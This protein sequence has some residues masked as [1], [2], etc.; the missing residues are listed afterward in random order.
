MHKNIL[1]R[2]LIQYFLEPV[3]EQLD[4]NNYKLLIQNINN[5]KINK[6]YRVNI[7]TI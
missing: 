5:K 3:Y 6:K 1:L 2:Q 7:I 4:N